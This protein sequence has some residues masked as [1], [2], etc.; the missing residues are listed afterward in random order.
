MNKARDKRL[1]K[2]GLPNPFR[3]ENGE[4]VDADSR[5]EAVKRFSAEQVQ[6]ALNLP[7][8]QK[9]VRIAIERRLKQLEREK[10]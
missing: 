8:L 2:I 3:T 6:V 10:A 9:T 4:Y 5:I 7:N 1:A